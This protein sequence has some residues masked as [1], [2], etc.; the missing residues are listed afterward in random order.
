[1]CT[2]CTRAAFRSCFPPFLPLFKLME[3]FGTFWNVLLALNFKDGA[4]RDLGGMENL[5]APIRK[6][7]FSS[8]YGKRNDRLVTL[9]QAL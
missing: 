1:M 3:M 6:P 2:V 9:E 8:I 7:E 4:E 5:S